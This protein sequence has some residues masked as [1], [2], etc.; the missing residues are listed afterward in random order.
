MKNMIMT[1]IA[2]TIMC[3]PSCV[4]LLPVNNQYEKAGT[5]QQGH[6]EV[7][8]FVTKY[9]RHGYGR[10]E[11]S[12]RNYGFRAGYGF[13]DRFD[14]K[15]RYERLV[16]TP[17]FDGK[18][19]GAHYFSFIPK[20]AVAPEYFSV[21]IPFSTYSVS[22]FYDGNK[23]KTRVNS[24]TPQMIFSVTNRKKKVDLSLA[25]KMDYLWGYDSDNNVF[26]GAS[27]GAGFSTDLRK[28]AIRPEVGISSDDGDI[29]YLSY[30][31]GFQWIIARKK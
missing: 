3:L 29:K 7:S 10:T 28:W 27:L 12:N 22:S 14:L 21:M 30:G 9:D 5:L 18:L 16:F 25:M 11:N 13:T 20:F 19:T 24:I 15:L 6:T 2:F 23:H 31:I 17:H 26:L 4:S 8:G 1:V